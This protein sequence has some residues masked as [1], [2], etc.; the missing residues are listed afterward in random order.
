MGGAT[1]EGAYSAAV[2]QVAEDFE[3]GVVTYPWGR[4]TFEADPEAAAK[5]RGMREAAVDTSRSQKNQMFRENWVE[6]QE[7]LAAE[8][9]SRVP[10]LIPPGQTQ[11]PLQSAAQ[12][13]PGQQAPF[14]NVVDQNI[15][16]HREDQRGQFDRLS[17]AVED[18]N[19]ATEALTD[20]IRQD[21]QARNPIPETVPIETEAPP[22]PW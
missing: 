12:L 3:A 16:G 8:N 20:E 15:T 10:G 6:E 18:G 13:P 17:K 22:V 2:N 5:L 1:A 7:A 4:K 14:G 21:R 9:S 19:Q 11:N